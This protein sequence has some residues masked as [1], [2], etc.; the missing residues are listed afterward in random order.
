LAR[1]DRAAL[2]QNCL[3]LA[4]LSAL[5]LPGFALSFVIL[6]QLTEGV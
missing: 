3:I 1:P 4:Q 2:N 5:L 6:G